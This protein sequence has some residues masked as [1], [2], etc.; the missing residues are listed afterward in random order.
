MYLIWIEFKIYLNHK[1][2]SYYS[3]K[4]YNTIKKKKK[5]KKKK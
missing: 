5:K 3:E 4:K 2:I 1:N